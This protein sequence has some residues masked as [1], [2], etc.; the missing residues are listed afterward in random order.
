L[1]ALDAAVELRSR[2]GLRRLALK[3]FITGPRKTA[4]E[5]DEIVTAIVVR[6]I[7]DLYWAPLGVWLIRE[8]MRDALAR[9]AAVF[10]DL[11]AA[12]RRM[13][14]RAR[15]DWRRHSH[16]LGTRYQATLTEFAP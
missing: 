11:A 7:N 10:P 9:P 13:D 4:R 1:L 5:P 2:R 16:F 12:T 14:E 3:D 8:T 6:A 15:T